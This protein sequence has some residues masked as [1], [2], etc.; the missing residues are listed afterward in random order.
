MAAGRTT[1]SVG[2]GNSGTFT[3]GFLS[4]DGTGAGTLTPAPTL[5]DST[6]AEMFGTTADSVATSDTG[7]FSYLSL[8]KRLLQ[9]M[10]ATGAPSVSNLVKGGTGQMTGTTSTAVT[11]IGAG[12]ANIY[13]Y[14]TAVIVSNAHATVDTEVVLQDGSGGT[15]FA[16]FPAQHGYGGAVINFVPPLKQTTANTALYAKNLTTGAAVTV[17]VNGYQAA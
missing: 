7:T 3:A 15:T 12:G 4:S 1:K 2:D 16:T 11:G 9:Y 5:Y 17:T 8:F 6:G 13:N 10:G 14:I